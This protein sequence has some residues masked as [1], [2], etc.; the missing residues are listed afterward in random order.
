[1]AQFPK[2][3]ELENKLDVRKVDDPEL[4]LVEKSISSNI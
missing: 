3:N 1:M 4:A 2:I